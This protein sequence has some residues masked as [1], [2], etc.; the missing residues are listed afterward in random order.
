MELYGRLNDWVRSE[1][2][3]ELEEFEEF[4]GFEMLIET[5]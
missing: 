5:C 4:D 1:R 2:V 3:A